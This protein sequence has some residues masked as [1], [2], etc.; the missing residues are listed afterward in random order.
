MSISLGSATRDHAAEVTVNGVPV[1]VT[2]IGTDGSLERACELIRHWDARADAI[3]LGGI[4]R[5][6]VVAGRRYPVEDAKRLV[7]AAS[8]APVCDGSGLK[9]V[10][11]RGQVVWLTEQ[12]WIHPEQPVLLVSALDRF[13]MAESFYR[14]GFPTVAGDLIFGAQINYPIHSQAE[15]EEMGRKLLPDLLKLSFEHLYPTGAQQD[16]PPDPRF[17]RYF[18]EASIVAG[19][20]HYIRRYMP[21][22]LDGKTVLTNTTTR[23]DVAMLR[24]RGARLLITTTPAIGGR[25]FGTNAL[26]AALVAATGV[27]PEDPRWPDT[28]GH[29]EELRL[30]IVVL[31]GGESV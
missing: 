31:N 5:Y 12:G 15:L 30:G 9:D 27:L 23:D 4:D 6:L 18:N 14:L 19:D 25:S 24:E 20:F 13:G 26:E 16:S 17:E 3:G 21:A 11:E 1:R 7:G 8:R 22:R 28:V 2:R 10:W 29:W